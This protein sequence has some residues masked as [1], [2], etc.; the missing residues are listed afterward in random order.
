MPVGTS[1]EALRNSFRSAMRGLAATVT[2]ISTRD[3]L[4]RFG[5]TA[6]SVTSVSVEPPSLLVSVNREASIH[7]P[8]A[9]GGAFCV[10]VLGRGHEDHCFAFSGRKEGEERF[11]GGAWADENGLPFLRDARAN[12]FCAVDATL[13]YATHTIFIGR[14]KQVVTREGVSP[15]VYL[16]GDFV[17]HVV[18][19]S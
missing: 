7:D 11:D 10:N 5:M 17:P 15:L 19:R 8:L 2:I 13:P 1:T 3:E 18:T 16:D 4:G 14:V 6:T 12:L 9:A